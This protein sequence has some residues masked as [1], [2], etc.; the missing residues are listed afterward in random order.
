MNLLC[1]QE[2]GD[3]SESC[4]P[5]CV[6]YVAMKV[7]QNTW[8]WP[9]LVSTTAPHKNI[10]T[11]PMM[12]HWSV[13]ICWSPLWCGS[14]SNACYLL[15]LE[16]LYHT[17]ATAKR[18]YFPCFVFIYVINTSYLILSDWLDS[19]SLAEPE[20][21]HCCQHGWNHQGKLIEQKQLH[22]LHNIDKVVSEDNWGLMFGRWHQMMRA[23]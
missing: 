8:K 10:D 11:W 16:R 5:I 13:S 9:V 1:L 4:R 20:Y 15:G 7:V 21:Q 18:L 12:Y 14:G 6:V 17:R 23:D 22:E 3:C 2:E 19:C